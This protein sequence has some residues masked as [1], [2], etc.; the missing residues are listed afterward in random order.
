MIGGA[1]VDPTDVRCKR[2]AFT[3]YRWLVVVHILAYQPLNAWLGNVTM[4]DLTTLGLLTEDE[5]RVLFPVQRKRRDEV[6]GWMSREI[7]LGVKAGL[8]HDTCTVTCLDSVILAWIYMDL[9]VS[10][11]HIGRF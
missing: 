8:L 6:F 5:E 4:H 7:Q 11:T 10:Y 9:Y 1:I 3:M 2:L